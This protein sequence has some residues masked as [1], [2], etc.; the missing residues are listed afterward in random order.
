M[1]RA[2][3]ND[4]ECFHFLSGWCVQIQIA[5]CWHPLIMTWIMNGYTVWIMHASTLNNIH[6]VSVYNRS[7]I[8]PE[9]LTNALTNRLLLAGSSSSHSGSFVQLIP[10]FVCLGVKFIYYILLVELFVLLVTDNRIWRIF[11]SSFGPASSNWSVDEDRRLE[12]EIERV[13]M[14]LQKAIKRQRRFAF[15]LCHRLASNKH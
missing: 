12:I 5:V 13:I 4:S 6:S 7:P 9:T 3:P 2:H 1:S 15:R 14:V 10:F 11:L 8:Y